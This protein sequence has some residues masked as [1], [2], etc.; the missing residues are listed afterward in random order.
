MICASKAGELIPETVERI[1]AEFAGTAKAV[2]VEL[3]PAPPGRR[4][5]LPFLPPSTSSLA[6]RR[7]KP[8]VRRGLS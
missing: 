3:E 4:P 2:P 8:M 7:R 1:L 5:T 6:T